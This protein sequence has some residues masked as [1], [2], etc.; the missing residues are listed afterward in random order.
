MVVVPDS[1]RL[2]S[3]ASVLW[4]QEKP[5]EVQ[6]YIRGWLLVGGGSAAGWNTKPPAAPPMGGPW[7]IEPQGSKLWTQVEQ[8]IQA[9]HGC[10]VG[11][12]KKW[13]DP[14]PYVIERDRAAQ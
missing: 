6:S 7:P 5:C 12:R 14:D 10:F 2:C 11:E 3:P 4:S 1:A 13:I 8:S 9:M